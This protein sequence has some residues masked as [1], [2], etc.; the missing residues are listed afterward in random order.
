MTGHRT[1]SSLAVGEEALVCEIEADVETRWRLLD[2]GLVPGT[3]IRVD[4]AKPFGRSGL[5]RVQRDCNGFEA[6][7][8]TNRESQGRRGGVNDVRSVAARFRR[9]A[10]GSGRHPVVALAGN[11][12]TG[13][14]RCLTV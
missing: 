12:N 6:G 5:V 11:P 9:R 3:R 2:L 10:S 13:R 7:G 14:Q 4:Q 1:L 8:C